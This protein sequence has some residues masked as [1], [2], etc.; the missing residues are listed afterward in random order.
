MHYLEPIS[1]FN[2]V[3][4]YFLKLLRACFRN[5]TRGFKI[6]KTEIG[7]FFNLFQG[8]LHSLSLEFSIKVL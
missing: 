6:F 8:L 1:V 7:Q 3:S 2:K 5:I 4:H